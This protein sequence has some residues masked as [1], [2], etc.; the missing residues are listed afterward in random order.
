MESRT[1]GRALF[2]EEEEIFY[3]KAEG[4]RTRMHRDIKNSPDTQEIKGDLTQQSFFKLET[5]EH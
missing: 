3:P 5:G 4:S 1:H 2:T